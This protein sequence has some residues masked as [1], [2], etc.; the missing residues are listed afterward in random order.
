MSW[1]DIRWAKGFP[2]F[3]WLG[4]LLDGLGIRHHNGRKTGYFVPEDM[5]VE[6]PWA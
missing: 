3:G 1:N 5:T 4:F 2:S 6:E